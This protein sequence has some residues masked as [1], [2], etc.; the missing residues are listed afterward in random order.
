MAERGEE[1]EAATEQ[2]LEQAS[3]AAVAL[4]LGR[5]SKAGKGFDEDARAF[6][7]KQTR[8]IDLQTEHL[9]EQRELQ[10]SRLRL[11]RWKDRVSLTLQSMTVVI[12]LAIALALAVMA[13][14]AHED[15]GVS[16]AAFSVPPDFAQR[17]L[18]G[19][20]VASEVL[21]RLAEFQ[22]RTVTARPASTYAND[23]GGDIKVEIPETGVSIG[24]LSRYLREWLGSETR[25][26]G[27]IVRTPQGLAVTA[28][29]GDAPGRRFEGLETDIDK[30]VGQTAEAI[31]AQT[32][33]YR[34]AV[35]LASHGRP[36]EALT[37]YQRL[38]A[39]GAP[40]DRPWAY[41]AWAALLQVRGDYAG[42]RDRARQATAFG[43]TADT[44]AFVSLL[45][46]D[47]FLSHWEAAVEDVHLLERTTRLGGNPQ[48]L[49]ALGIPS[50]DYRG[51]VAHPRTVA[52]DA[53]GNAGQVNGPELS[54]VAFGR[55][56]DL[57]G[58]RRFAR[59]TG[60]PG[61]GAVGIAIDTTGFATFSTDDWPGLEQ[62]TRLLVGL[63][64][65]EFQRRFI[66]ATL[67]NAV[68]AQGRQAEAEALVV[69]TPLDCDICVDARAVIAAR[70]GDWAAAERWMAVL[71]R[72]TPSVP[73][74]PTEWGKLLLD[75]GDADG[76]IAKLKEAH[77]RGPHFADPLELWGEAL[78]K[79][80][81]FAG[82]VGR[83]AEADKYAPRWGRNHLLWGEAL[84]RV[85][86]ADEARAQLSA[87][88]G[89]DLSVADRAEL[90][91]AQVAAPK[92]TS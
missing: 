17:G 14:R 10:T 20:V 25:I 72:R 31:Y 11:G 82:A 23:W 41:A 62:G 34:H 47:H 8:L 12:G 35:Y 63:G 75:R 39:T 42:S 15:H 60:L 55:S 52:T 53:E 73:F 74:A 58:A 9:H 1:P 43:T 5:T 50:G 44:G 85:G 26:S 49:P 30:L 2:A 4:A 81:D 6:L 18:T 78:T 79:K 88:A 37:A 64:P 13:W 70:R 71:D 24:E 80:G 16:I 21:D 33:P 29:A 61:D 54:L 86:K 38:A 45:G 28:R 68:S 87:A 27:E 22:S 19:Q 84:A 83:F 77:R 46:S 89:M 92:R 3:P 7:R 48:Y 90:V 91:K 69:Q 59:E 40:E 32:Q 51:L 67:A 65:D 76:A 57:A 56:H 66:R 36:D